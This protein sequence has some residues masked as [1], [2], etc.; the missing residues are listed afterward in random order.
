MGSKLNTY[1]VGNNDLTAMMASENALTKGF[2]QVSLTNWSTTA[3]PQIALGSLIECDGALYQSTVDESI[4]GSTSDGTLYIKTVP[5]SNTVTFEFSTTAPTWDTSKQGWYTSTSSNERYL[6]FVIQR[7]GSIFNKGIIS[8]SE[9]TQSISTQNSIATINNNTWIA[10]TTTFSNYITVS[11]GDLIQI[12]YSVDLTCETASFGI[13]PSAK[14]ENSGTASFY[15]TNTASL[16]KIN[17]YVSTSFYKYEESYIIKAQSQGTYIPAEYFSWNYS[18]AASV[19]V[20]V[21]AQ[22]RHVYVSKLNTLR[23]ST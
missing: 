6:E 9:I 23:V 20:N 19:P 3:V 4:G 15:S 7:S 21:Y 18:S 17:G 1:A 5:S 22:N 12:Y 14:V 2:H 13:Y 16:K 10:S 8:Q 11:A